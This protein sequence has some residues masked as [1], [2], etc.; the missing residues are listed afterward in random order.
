MAVR[1]EPRSKKTGLWPSAHEIA[2]A[3]QLFTDTIDMI[4]PEYELK[5][6]KNSMRTDLLQTRRA[7]REIPRTTNIP[8]NLVLY[9]FY[10]KFREYKRPAW[11]EK[12]MIPVSDAKRG[13]RKLLSNPA[14]NERIKGLG[15]G[16]YR[17]EGAI[18]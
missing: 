9:V 18:I 7:V 8:Q 5:R 11:S 6:R 10:I 1:V 3:D 14:V 12:S 16:N 13:R 15:W 17:D 4:E 2:C